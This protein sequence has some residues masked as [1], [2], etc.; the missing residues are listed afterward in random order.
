MSLT[1]NESCN[2]YGEYSQI[3]IHKAFCVYLNREGKISGLILDA[4][5][6]FGM[7]SEQI[8]T[9]VCMCVHVTNTYICMYCVHVV[10]CALVVFASHVA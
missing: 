7:W 8:R 10:A 4:T 2:K 3:C 1:V 6:F 5:T 9:Y